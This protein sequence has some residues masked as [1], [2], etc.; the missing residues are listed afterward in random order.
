[1][2]SGNQSRMNLAGFHL[3]VFCRLFMWLCL[4]RLK[5][6]ERECTAK[7][8]ESLDRRNKASI[9][10]EKAI[11]HLRFSGQGRD[12]VAIILL[13]YSTSRNLLKMIRTPSCNEIIIKKR[14]DPSMPL[15]SPL[16]LPHDS[17][18]IH[19]LNWKDTVFTSM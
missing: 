8:N 2:S 10:E 17:R 5:D 1:M 3:P 18:L 19:F 6:V 9:L 11:S 14:T 4:A 16:P 7:G 15:F 13:S 12:W